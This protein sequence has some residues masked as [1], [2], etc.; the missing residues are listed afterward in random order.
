MFRRTVCT[1]R[2]FFIHLNFLPIRD[3][4]GLRDYS[5]NRIRA[6]GESIG[7]MMTGL[8]SNVFT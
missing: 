2:L 8:P 4:N 6:Y 1:F 7:I 3:E 5:P